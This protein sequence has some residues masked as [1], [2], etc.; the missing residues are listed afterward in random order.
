MARLT[1]SGATQAEVTACKRMIA[2]VQDRFGVWPERL[3]ADIAEVQ[4]A[5]GKLYL[6]VGIDR[7]SKFDVTQ[8][9]DKAD[10]R[11]AWEVLEHLL[12][13]VPYR[14]HTILTDNGIQFAEQPRHRNTA[15]P[16]QLR[17]DMICEANDIERRLTKPNRPWTNGQSLPRR[18]PG[19]GG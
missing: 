15:W 4:T 5:E 8:L 12:Q 10:Q 16:R 17:F 18:G 13:A 2:R 19:S 1:V 3:A 7:T 6:F 9:V 14:I 11:T